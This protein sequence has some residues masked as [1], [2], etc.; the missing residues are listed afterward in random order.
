MGQAGA[1]AAT[2][3]AATPFLDKLKSAAGPAS[4]GIDAYSLLMGP[5]QA[6]NQEAQARSQGAVAN[7]QQAAWQSPEY[8][9]WANRYWGG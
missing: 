7:R 8:L 4:L 1:G 5:Q 9:A 2:A 3:P 6:A